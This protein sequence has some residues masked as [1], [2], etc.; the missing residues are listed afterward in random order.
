MN[1]IDIVLLLVMLVSVIFAVYRGFLASLLGVIACVI[2]F[3]VTM[4]A[5]PKLANAL[6]ANQGVTT[7]LSTFTDAGSIV[8]DYTLARTPV[9]IL[10]EN[11]LDAILGSVSLPAVM[12]DVL[13]GSM[14]AVRQ[15]GDYSKTVSDCVTDTVLTAVLRT[16]SFLLCFFLCLLALHIVINLF[17]H[18]LEF[19]ILRHLDGVFAALMGL[20]RGAAVVYLLMLLVPLLRT[21]LPFDLL[22]QYIGR[23]T[24]V[25]WLYDSRL[26]LR[27]IG[28]G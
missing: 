3:L 8:S 23:S 24:L 1:I 16:G 15:A 6:A 11:T 17:S 14:R 27:V 22:E 9:S 10:D 21:V 7:L 28:I 20:A 25:G 2:S 5:G 13:R 4:T 19:P 26:F 18:I 12:Q